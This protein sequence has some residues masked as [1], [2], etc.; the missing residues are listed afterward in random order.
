MLPSLV[1]AKTERKKK[2]PAR[3][4]SNLMPILV[5]LPALFQSRIA[6]GE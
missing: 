5:Y 2:A 1:V 4:T 3:G 6:S